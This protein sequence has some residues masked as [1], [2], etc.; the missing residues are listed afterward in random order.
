MKILF[1]GDIVGRSGRR[2]V[3]ELLPKIREDERIDL[4]IANA[5]NAAGGSGL[6]VKVVEE[7]LSSSIDCLT[8]GDHVWSKRDVLQ[9]IDTEPRLLRPANY[10]SQAPGRGST[11]IKTKGDKLVGVL[12]LQGR[13]FME[14]IDCPFRTAIN[15]VEKLKEKTNIVIVDF[16]AEATSEKEALGFWLDGRVTAVL[17]THTHVQTADERILPNGTAYITD[18]GMTGPFLSILGRDIE[19]VIKRFLT[20]TPTRMEVANEDLRLQG[21]IIEVDEDSGRAIQIRR[22]QYKLSPGDAIR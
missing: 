4:T 2:V 16:H 10:P 20:S 18:V 21:A 7:L 19:A 6:T 22:V 1:I 5:E 13:I 17:G 3:K 8:S 9:I 12:N 11:L 15:E 14:P